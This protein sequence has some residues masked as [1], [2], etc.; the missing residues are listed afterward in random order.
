MFCETK[1]TTDDLTRELRLDGWPALCIHGDKRQEERDWVS[2][3]PSAALVCPG[4]RVQHRAIL[5]ARLWGVK[6]TVSTKQTHNQVRGYARNV[7]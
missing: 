3:P 5:V 2:L 6:F 1:R 4:T 7:F